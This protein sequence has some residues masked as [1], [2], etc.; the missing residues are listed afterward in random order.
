M[1]AST[2]NTKNLSLLV[3]AILLPLVFYAQ[4]NTV[5]AQQYFNSWDEYE[6]HH[7]DAPHIKIR[8]Y[9]SNKA[10]C[11]LI[12]YNTDKHL[13]ALQIDLI[14]SS[15]V[16]SEN[17][18]LIKQIQ[19]EVMFWK[20]GKK[21]HERFF[22]GEKRIGKWK[23]WDIHGNLKFTYLHTPNSKCV[24]QQY[25]PKGSLHSLTL[26]DEI[27]D[28]SEQTYYFEN[29]RK[30][31]SGKR[32]IPSLKPIKTVLSSIQIGNWKYWHANGQLMQKGKY[33]RGKKSGTWRF[34]NKEGLL[35][36]K[37]KYKEGEVI[38]QSTFDK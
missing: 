29:G 6:L 31:R 32:L 13:T 28:I 5:I 2:H 14:D 23:Y 36:R 1:F 17:I 35:V 18:T 9:S 22:E 20:N 26:L 4:K 7:F 37:A 3:I 33:E 11:Y 19:K 24:I 16:I 15:Y 27:S 25:Y 34:Y 21:R 8:D 12:K 10:D 30:M 38:K